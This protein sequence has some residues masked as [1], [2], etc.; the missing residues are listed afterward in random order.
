MRKLFVIVGISNE[1]TEN[2]GKTTI[3]LNT[4]FKSKLNKLYDSIEYITYQGILD[5]GAVFGKT[6]LDPARVVFEQDKVKRIIT[7]IE[8]RIKEAQLQGYEVDVLAHSLGCWLISKCNVSIRSFYACGHPIGWKGLTGGSKLV[9]RFIVRNNITTWGWTKPPLRCQYY[10]NLYSRK[11]IVG[12]QP[13][14]PD[15]DK[16]GFGATEAYEIDTGKSHDFCDYTTFLNSKNAIFPM[17]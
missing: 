6:L 10:L 15:N 8:F 13:S 12:N 14:I 3:D 17:T 16:W 7:E 4:R 5:K 11:D 1:N 2:Y 9:A